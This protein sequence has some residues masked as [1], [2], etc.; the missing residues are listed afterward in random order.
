MKFFPWTDSIIMSLWHISYHR[1][2]YIWLTTHSSIS[3]S[4]L[5]KVFCIL[6]KFFNLRYYLEWWM[7][8]SIHLMK[9][10]DRLYNNESMAYFDNIVSFIFWLTIHFS[11]FFLHLYQGLNFAYGRFSIGN[12]Y[13]ERWRIKHP[14]N[15]PKFSHL[16]PLPIL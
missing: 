9:G 6:W 15:T 3:S 16:H 8:F 12:I 13:I 4:Y 2:L 1:K 7:L 14:F 5:S 10:V 11:I